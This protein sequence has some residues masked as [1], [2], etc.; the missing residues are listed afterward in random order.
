MKATQPVYLTLDLGNTSA[1]AALFRGNK[2]LKASTIRVNG[3]AGLK[4]FLSRMAVQPEA[5]LVSSVV[6]KDPSLFA[7]LRSTMVT[8][9]L[10]HGLTLPIRNNYLTPKTLGQDRLACAAGAWALF[11]GRNLLVI[12]AGTCIKYDIVDASGRY[13]GGSIAPGLQMRFEAL[14]QYTSALPLVK[15]RAL[16]HVTGRNTRQSILSGVEYGIRFEMQGFIST[17]EKQYKNLK[18]VMTGGDGLRL[19]KPLKNDI[20]AAPHLIHI[21]LYEI[22]KKN[23]A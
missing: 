16:N 20:F 6:K 23:L 12:D 17:Y 14:H 21:G 10:H 19:A 11:P 15:P 8:T 18:V 3:P 13:C 2:L 5:C 7:Y 9:S 22:L 1:S 4:S